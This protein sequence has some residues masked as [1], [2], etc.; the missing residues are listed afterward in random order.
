MKRNF[1]RLAIPAALILW[2]V[3]GCS[4]WGSSGP[5]ASGFDQAFSVE[6]QSID[7]VTQDGGCLDVDGSV[8]CAPDAELPSPGPHLPG[9]P[10]PEEALVIEPGSGSEI[11]CEPLP[12]ED[13]CAFTMSIGRTGFPDGSA[14]YAAVRLEEKKSYWVSGLSPFVQSTEDPSRLELQIRVTGLAADETKL[15]QL[16][17]LVYLPGSELPPIETGDLLLRDFGA[18]RS[19]VVDDVSVVPT[20][21]N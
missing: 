14:Y 1:H 10:E 11:A 3:S 9:S 2:T 13:A 19:Y 16:A 12:D 18:D 4:G 17:V 15:M 5:K 7:Q 6:Q 8:V 20:E 21:S